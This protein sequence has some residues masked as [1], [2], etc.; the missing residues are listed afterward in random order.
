MKKIVFIFVQIRVYQSSIRRVG[1]AS[2]P[3][4]PQRVPPRWQLLESLKGNTQLTSRRDC[5]ER[6][7]REQLKAELA[8]FSGLAFV[9][10]SSLEASALPSKGF[11]L[12]AGDCWACYFNSSFMI[13]PDD[14][15]WDSSVINNLNSASTLH[16]ITCRLE[17]HLCGTR[18]GF[19]SCSLPPT[20]PPSLP[21]LLLSPVWHKVVYLYRLY[22][23]L[24]AV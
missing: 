3:F 22:I 2:Q 13:F 18:T 21:F 10:H 11:A 8:E 23:I 15:P 17:M 4:L 14:L 6:L 9:M 16:S 24:Q 1:G 5:Y 19:C 7:Q 12:T 20:P